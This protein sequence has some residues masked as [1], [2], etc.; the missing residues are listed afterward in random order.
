MEQPLG[1]LFG[2][3]GNAMVFHVMSTKRDGDAT[4]QAT[5]TKRARS[6]AASCLV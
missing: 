2:N 3:A 1:R 5:T 6:A 4:A